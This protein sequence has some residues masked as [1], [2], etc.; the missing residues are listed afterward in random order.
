MIV[1]L[2]AKEKRI[3]KITYDTNTLATL[4]LDEDE[5]GWLRGTVQNPLH[6]LSPDEENPKDKLMRKRF[7]DALNKIPSC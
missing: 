5:W 3:M 6:G 7:W 4:V 1:N 2:C